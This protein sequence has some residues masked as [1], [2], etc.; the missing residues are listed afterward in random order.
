MYK[1]GLTS[2][3]LKAHLRLV[4]RIFSLDFTHT[5][6]C[7]SLQA[8]DDERTIPYPLECFVSPDGAT[9]HLILAHPTTFATCQVPLLSQPLVSDIALPRNFIPT[10]H[11]LSLPPVDSVYH[12]QRTQHRLYSLCSILHADP[13][14]HDVF[15]TITLLPLSLDRGDLTI[16]ATEASLESNESAFRLRT[17]P[18]RLATNFSIV[19]VTRKVASSGFLVL[20]AHVSIEVISELT[21]PSIV[22]FQL[23]LKRFHPAP[24]PNAQSCWTSH[25]LQ[26]PPALRLNMLFTAAPSDWIGG[27]FYLDERSRQ[28]VINLDDGAVH[29][30]AW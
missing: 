20:V 21:W 14:D 13:T 3:R 15:E 25:M 10:L 28:V 8:T 1:P 9:L 4:I 30:I 29:V 7:L 27:E 24:H 22:S 16:M 6:Y 5:I 18:K 12:S 2:V 26:L 19:E 23:E 11:D 17:N